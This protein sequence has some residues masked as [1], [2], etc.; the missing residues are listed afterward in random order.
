[1]NNNTATSPLQMLDWRI[2]EFSASNNILFPSADIPH[3]WKIKAS[4][5]QFDSTDNKLHATVSVAFHFYAEQ[6]EGRICFEGIA[7]SY[8]VFEKDKSDADNPEELFD[9]LLHA[10]AMTNM[11]GNLRLFLLQESALFQTG[12]KKV[13]L[14][15]INLNDFQ[16]N[17]EYSFTV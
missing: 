3:T 9:K 6:N 13:I 10:S 12:A 16:F 15:F 5:N 2:A 17:E 7:V 1:M 11:F 14:P 4:I 8:Y